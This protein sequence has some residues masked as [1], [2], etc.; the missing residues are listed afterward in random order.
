MECNGL[1]WDVICIE[2]TGNVYTVP[3]QCMVNVIVNINAN[4]MDRNEMWSTVCVYIYIWA[5]ARAPDVFF[6]F[7]MCIYIF[8]PEF[9]ECHTSGEER[10][11]L[12]RGSQRT[13]LRLLGTPRKTERCGYPCWCGRVVT[14][15]IS[16]GTTLGDWAACRWFWLLCSEKIGST[17]WLGAFPRPAGGQMSVRRSKTFFEMGGWLLFD[18]IPRWALWICGHWVCLARGCDRRSTIRSLWSMH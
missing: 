9:S 13:P 2:C 7:N 18:A 6:F 11:W 3:M 17:G 8:T 12:Q 10:I 1:Q 5:Y 16:R 15:H 4:S 14:E